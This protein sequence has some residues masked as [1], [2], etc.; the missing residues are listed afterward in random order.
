M[1]MLGPTR[2]TGMRML[3][4]IVTPGTCAEQGGPVPLAPMCFCSDLIVISHH[5]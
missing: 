2:K 3:E 5:W 1:H 4:Y